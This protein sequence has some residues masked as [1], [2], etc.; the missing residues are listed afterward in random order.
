[1]QYLGQKSL[2]IYLLHFFFLFPLTAL[3]EPMRAMGLGFVPLAAVSVF[4]ACLII[5]ASLL[6]NVVLSLSPVL[7]SLLTG[8]I[9]K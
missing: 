8:K 6:A 5:A 2:E 1:M 4:V 7:A 9:S 3:Q